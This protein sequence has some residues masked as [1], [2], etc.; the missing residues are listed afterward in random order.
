MF[1]RESA[2][3]PLLV[4]ALLLPACAGASPASEEPGTPYTF[5]T[6]SRDG[7]GKIYMGREISFALGH[8]G[9]RWLERPERLDEERPDL[10]VDL[11][12]LAPDAVIADIGAGSGY[13][14]FRLRQRV[15]EGKVIA[16]DIDRRMLA[17][18]EARSEELG[19]SNVETVL[20]TVEDPGLSAASVDAVLMVDAYHEFSHPKEMMEGI[21]RALVP[22]GLVYLVEYRA[23]DPRVPMLPLHKMS[24]EQ[25]RREMD[26]AGLEFVENR[27]GLPWQH[28]MVFRKSAD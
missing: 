19:V 21:S 27:P 5:K 3:A 6:P 15:P 24:E 1:V 25:A 4:L 11:L 22:G 20:G 23:E 2:L 8:R 28:L 18:V 13:L 16:V 9:I 26:A 7:I 10:L 14:S 17:A 12:E